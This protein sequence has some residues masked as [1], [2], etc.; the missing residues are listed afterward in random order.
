MKTNKKVNAI[1][2][3][4]GLTKSEKQMIKDIG[5]K[6]IEDFNKSLEKAGMTIEQFC[7]FL[8]P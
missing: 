2:S 7:E 5:L 3:L 6:A 8:K 1:H 4:D